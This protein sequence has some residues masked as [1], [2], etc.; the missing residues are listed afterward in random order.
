M[1]N[2]MPPQ[3]QKY[4]SHPMAAAASNPNV[5]KIEKAKIGEKKGTAE[6]ALMTVMTGILPGFD[7]TKDFFEQGLSSLDTVKMVTR[8]GENGYSIEMKDIYLHSNFDELV[9]CMK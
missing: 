1:M 3:L 7:K 2:G 5:I 9:K 8:C 6:E 4:L